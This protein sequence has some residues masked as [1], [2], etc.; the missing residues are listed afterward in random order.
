[1]QD[2]TYNHG[3][4]KRRKKVDREALNSAFMRIPRMHIEAARTLLD[5]GLS[6]IYELEGRCPEAL[7]NENM[8]KTGHASDQVKPYL[9]LAVYFAENQP[10]DPELLHPDVWKD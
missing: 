5:L 8:Q 3:Q 7:F 6:E 9:R 1:M 2:D 4:N 10:P